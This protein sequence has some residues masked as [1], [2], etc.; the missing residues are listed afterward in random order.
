MAEKKKNFFKKIIEELDEKME[1]KSKDDSGC[2]SDSN[3]CSIDCS[4]KSKKT[5][6][7]DCGEG[8]SCC[9]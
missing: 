7:S 1:E 5:N 6:S 2:C 3:A 9:N 8:N 4:P